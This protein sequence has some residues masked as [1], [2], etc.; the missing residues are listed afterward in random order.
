MRRLAGLVLVAALAACGG[1]SPEFPS[2]PPISP[3][4]TATGPSVPESTVPS[5]LPSPVGALEQGKRYFAVYLAVGQPGSR[6][7]DDAVARLADLGIAAG[8]GDIACDEGA[9]ESLGVPPDSSAVGVY[10]E[11][12]ED[13]A[14][15][16]AA[17]DPPGMGP[18]PVRTFCAD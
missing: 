4:A 11:R 14:T 15:F 6:D 1:S 10:F 7:L 2:A 9:A 12:E 17:L 18:V 13:A 16:A 8:A 3:P 5:P